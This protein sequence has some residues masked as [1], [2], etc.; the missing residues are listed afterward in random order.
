ML[1]V[2]LQEAVT[3]LKAQEKAMTARAAASEQLSGDIVESLTAGLL[4][5]D[6]Q[7][8]ASRSSIRPAVAMLG[9]DGQCGRRSITTTCCPRFRR[10]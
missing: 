3:K 9:C 8:A 6:Q 4:V 2:A 1:S 10:S 7:P 5:V